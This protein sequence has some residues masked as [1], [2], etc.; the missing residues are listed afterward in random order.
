MT[1]KIIKGIAGFYYVH[2]GENGIYTCKAKGVF[3]K[4]QVK[5]LVGDDVE[6][7]VL[8]EMA[9][10]AGG[11]VLLYTRFTDCICENG[12]ITAVILNAL[13]GLCAVSAD[14]FVDAT[15]NADVAKAAG[16]RRV[17]VCLSLPPSCLRC[18]MSRMTS[19]I[20]SRHV[21]GD[22]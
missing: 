12:K 13:E 20:P 3:R 11:E 19:T 14:V 15:G 2:T 6:M 7:S 18:A 1:G 9:K 5:P 4:L 22:R 10:E 8:D 17:A 21:Q 16:V